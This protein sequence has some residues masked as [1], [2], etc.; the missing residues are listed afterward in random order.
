MPVL[1]ADE[2]SPSY[3]YKNGHRN[4]LLSHI[5]RPTDSINFER[6]RLSTPDDDFIDIDCVFNKNERLV[7]LCHGLEGSSSSSYIQQFSRYFNEHGFDVAAINYRGCSGEMNRQLRM[8]H[9]GATDD[10]HLTLESF[11]ADYKSVFLIGFSLGGNL[12]LKYLGDQIYKLPTQLKAAV[13]ISTPAHLESCSLKIIQRENW[14]YEK[15]F[16]ISLTKKLR[17]KAKLFKDQINLS[18]LKG[19]SNLYEFDDI[20]TA[21]LHGFKD[22]KDYYTRCSSKQFLSNIKLPTLMLSAVDDP[23]LSDQAIPIDEAA[24]NDNLFL[25]P[26]TYGGHVG[27]HIKKNQHSWM[28]LKSL[29]FISTYT[30]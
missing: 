3:I 24:E 16:M 21:P 12:V 13:A 11:A 25:Y 17:E 27:F 29:E 28:E 20:Y 15:R 14:I 9:S 22:A 6:K 26:C 8:Y 5:L 1:A 4:T 23:F 18:K 7:I 10:V 30:L 2:Y 19:L